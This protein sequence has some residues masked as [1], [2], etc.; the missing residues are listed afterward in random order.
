MGDHLIQF[1]RKVQ[2]RI[3]Q[4]RQL[5][6]EPF[7]LKASEILKMLKKDS[8]NFFEEVSKRCQ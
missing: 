7:L 8:K 5:R 1:D 6:K 3:T 4:R 2:V